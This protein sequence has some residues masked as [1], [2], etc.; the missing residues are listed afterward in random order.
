MTEFKLQPTQGRGGSQLIDYK[1]WKIQF[2]MSRGISIKFFKQVEGV[3]YKAKERNYWYVK[4]NNEAIELAIKYV[5]NFESNLEEGLKKQI[6]I[7]QE[8]QAKKV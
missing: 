3:W 5:D 7:K 1:G 4:F 2:K 6:A 8:K